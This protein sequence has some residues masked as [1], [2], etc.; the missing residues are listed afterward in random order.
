MDGGGYLLS[1]VM[2]YVIRLNVIFRATLF[3]FFMFL[4]R[5]L[6]RSLP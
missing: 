5:R 4:I 3:V 1:Y 6:L 2:F